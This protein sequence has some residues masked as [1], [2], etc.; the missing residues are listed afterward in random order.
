LTREG[1]CLK[2]PLNL[3]CIQSGF[4][5]YPIG[6]YCP[7]GPNS[8]T[9]VGSIAHGCNLPSNIV[10][11]AVPGFDDTPPRPN[12][13]GPD[14]TQMGLGGLL[15]CGPKDCGAATPRRCHSRGLKTCRQRPFRK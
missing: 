4:S 1:T 7:A 9:F 2:T 14:W 15:N 10:L 5:I 12:T 6:A 13:F 3:G 8:N 11:P